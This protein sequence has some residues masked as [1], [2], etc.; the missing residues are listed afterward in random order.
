VAQATGIERTVE[1]V[2]E[3]AIVRAI[4]SPAVERAL[5]RVVRGPAVEEAV[6]G[7]LGSPAVERA[8]TD[9]LDSEL[10]DRVWQRLLAS[11]EAQRLVERI[12]EAPEVRSAIASQGVGF[13]DDIRRELARA[14]RRLDDVVQRIARR[15]LGRRG[16]LEPSDRAG[17][18]SRL[19]AFAIDIGMLNALFFALSAL[20]ALVA[21]IVFPGSATAPA[22][23]FGVGA[24]LLAGGLYMTSF[25]A[26][27]RQTP[28]MRFLGIR[29]QAAE[30]GAPTVRSGI[31]RLLGMALAT[32]PLGLG[33]VGLLT[34]RRGLHD[35][36]ARTDVR[37][38]PLSRQAPWTGPEPE[39]SVPA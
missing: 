6:R 14:A 17:A 34:K 33:W 5:V 4:E 31:R 22:L 23:A 37:Y 28:G 12:A 27:A 1:A 25:W 18:V 38:E 39:E 3:E 2:T 35:R 10:V 20:V 19:L 26:L 7:A 24:W 30:G 8:L 13:L 21:S 9:A 15:I 36:M 11:D 16:A 32:L 29:I